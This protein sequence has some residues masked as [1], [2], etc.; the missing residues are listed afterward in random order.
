MSRELCALI[1][2]LGDS[3][4]FGDEILLRANSRY[5]AQSSK[6]KDRFIYG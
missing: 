5:Q 6:D 2:V 1:F 3:I 4:A